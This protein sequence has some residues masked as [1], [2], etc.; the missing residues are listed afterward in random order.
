MKRLETQRW[1]ALQGTLFTLEPPQKN[2]S[3]TLRLDSVRDLGDRGTPQA[4]LPCC[5]LVFSQQAP[6]RGHAP[7]GIYQLVHPELDA[8]EL[9]VVPLGPSRG[10]RMTYE[11]IL[12]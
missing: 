9:F 7:Q 1:C 10:A 11:I 4:P 3:I 8:Q 6:E 2:W 5:S 12:N